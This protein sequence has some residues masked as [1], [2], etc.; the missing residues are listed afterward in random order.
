M[1]GSTTVD[2]FIIARIGA[3]FVAVGQIRNR[4]SLPEFVSF[5]LRGES[6]V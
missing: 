1:V 4:D 6:N 2:L 3:E 5:S